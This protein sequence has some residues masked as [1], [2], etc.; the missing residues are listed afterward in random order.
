LPTIPSNDGLTCDR[1]AVRIDLTS[2]LATRDGQVIALSDTSFRL[3]ACLA[4]SPGRVLP[5]REALTE[6]WGPEHAEDL[7]A[8][9]AHAALLRRA[10]EA[11]PRRPRLVVEVPG[12]GIK[13]R[14]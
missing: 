11:N 8:L 14:A 12:V 1:G 5:Y 13:L 4:A 6:V 7:P 9:Q 10:I 2:R 3:L